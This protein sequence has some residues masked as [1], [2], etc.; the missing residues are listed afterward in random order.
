MSKT[1][2]IHVLVSN[3]PDA[4][5]T[6]AARAAATVRVSMLTQPDP[7]R[8]GAVEVATRRRPRLRVVWDLRELTH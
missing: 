1:Y 2:Q 6:T 3:Q 5:V 8:S 7:E 4:P